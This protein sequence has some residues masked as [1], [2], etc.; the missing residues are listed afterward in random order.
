MTAALLAHQG[1]WD[2]I[3][4]V[5]VPI[6]IFA[7]LLVVANRRANSIDGARHGTGPPDGDTGNEDGH[8]RGDQ[9]DRGRRPGGPP[10]PGGR[11]QPRR[12][13]PTR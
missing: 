1:G 6:V 13:P 5:L 8:G 7:A 10:D 9:G 11:R 3:L 2:E 4:M 12:G